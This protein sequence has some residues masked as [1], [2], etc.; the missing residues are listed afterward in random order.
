MSRINNQGFTLIELMVV[1]AVVAIIAT[2]AIPGLQAFVASNRQAGAVNDFLSSLYFAR[3]EAITRN[4]SVTLCP[5]T[6]GAGCDAAGWEG[7]HIVFVDA[8]A[9]GSLDAGEDLLSTTDPLPAGMTLRSDQFNDFLMYRPNGRARVA[10]PNV[11]QGR[12]SICAAGAVGQARVTD[13]GISGRPFARRL[14]GDA[15]VAICGG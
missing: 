2:V 14:T 11:N 6:D 8:D 10:D 4:T 9:D 15:A 7:G 5:S 12:F 13:I 3:D 1:V